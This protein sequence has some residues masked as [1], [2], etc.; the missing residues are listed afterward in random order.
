VTVTL[1]ALGTAGSFIYTITLS[2]AA[3]DDSVTTNNITT[4]VVSIPASG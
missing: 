3:G 2:P 4:V 1:P